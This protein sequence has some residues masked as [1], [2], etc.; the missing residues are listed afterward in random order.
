[1]SKVKPFLCVRPNKEVA[2]QVAA[3]PYDVYNRQ[4]AKDSKYQKLLPKFNKVIEMSFLDDE[5]KEMYKQS[6][7]SRLERL[8]R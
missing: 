8:N 6:I 4:E 1:M 5:D 7:A 3:L 2:D